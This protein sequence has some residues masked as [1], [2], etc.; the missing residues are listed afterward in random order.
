M[1]DACFSVLKTSFSATILT[2]CDTEA[3]MA[4]NGHSRANLLLNFSTLTLASFIW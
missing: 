4:A 2:A 3:D 1:T